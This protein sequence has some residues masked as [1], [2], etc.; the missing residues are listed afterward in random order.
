MLLVTSAA[1]L[2]TAQDSRN[3]G[4]AE[5]KESPTAANRTPWTTSR[6]KGTPDPPPS[7][8]AERLFP[9]LN[10][11]EPTVITSAPGTD[12]LFVAEQRGK[13]Y[14]FPN[15]QA[16]EEA[17]L[18]VDAEDLTARLRER[19]KDDIKF[20]AVYGLTFHPKF[21]ENRYC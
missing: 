6:V 17:N 21:A 14:S 3:T 1:G 5:K 19:T 16:C 18:F 20:D 11:H 10:F 15:D 8:R 12:R 2:L 9:K 4:T 13:V 7:F